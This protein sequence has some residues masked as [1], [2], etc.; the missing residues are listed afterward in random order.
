MLDKL[1][2]FFEKHLKKAEAETQE[3]LEHRLQLACAVLLIEVAYADDSLSLLEQDKLNQ[4]I[5]S[6]FLL[7]SEEIKSLVELAKNKS[8]QATDYYQFTRLLN[9]NFEVLQKIRLV[10]L[11]WEVALSDGHI[12]KHEE[13][14]IRKIA[15]LLYLRHSEL[16]S[17]RERVKADLKKA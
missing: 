1:K 16:I 10:E 14:F 6:K 11:M 13:H 12:D 3:A 15:E 8:E 5:H 17:A 9:D 7:S 2:S 4:A